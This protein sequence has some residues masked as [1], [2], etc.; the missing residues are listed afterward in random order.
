MSADSPLVSIVVPV[1]K[2]E[3]FVR[4]SLDSILAQR[5]PA[6]EVRLERAD[7]QNGIASPR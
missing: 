3:R 4:A 1:C 6:I 5:H 2:G 7:P